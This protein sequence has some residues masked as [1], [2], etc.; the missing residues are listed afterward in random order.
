MK[1][2]VSLRSEIFALDF[3]RW[4][5]YFVISNSGSCGSASLTTSGTIPS[6]AEGP[7]NS[8]NFPCGVGK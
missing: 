1:V 2:K 6:Y 7:P 5:R 8:P 4:V 3:S